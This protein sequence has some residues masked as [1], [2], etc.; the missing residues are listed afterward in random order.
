[1]RTE[2]DE[3]STP[4]CWYNLQQS[5]LFRVCHNWRKKNM[6]IYNN[7]LISNRN[8]G[9]VI[10]YVSSQLHNTAQVIW[11]NSRVRPWRNFYRVS[12]K[13]QILVLYSRSRVI[14]FHER[15]L[16]CPTGVNAAAS[17]P[18]YTLPQ[19]RSISSQITITFI[20]RCRRWLFI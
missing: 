19:Q 1:M 8:N 18:V 20:P 4:Y 2:R 9:E 10:L 6:T 17:P 5:L 13:K 12:I 3:C 11:F 16:L 15:F 7:I 14:L